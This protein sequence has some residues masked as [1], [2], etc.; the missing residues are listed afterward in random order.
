[1]CREMQRYGH[2][3]FRSLKLLQ[4][5]GMVLGLPEI[6]DSNDVCQGCVLGKHH[7][8]PFS[9]E[10]TWRT[11]EPLEL[12]HSDVCGPMKVPTTSAN[13]YFLMF[14]DDYSR[15]C[16]VYFIRNKSEVFGIFKKFR[17]MVELQCGYSLK[18]LRSDRGGEFTSTEFNA[19][20]ES[21]GME[22]QLTVIY[23]IAVE[24]LGYHVIGQRSVSTNRW[25]C[26]K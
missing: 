12:I 25:N 7:R 13:R 1:M 19:F 17:A 8:E 5:E 24:P 3:N 22:R 16:W 20:C 26:S 10:I 18:K 6:Q 2:L 4:S 15:I 14:I 23:H 9:K 11:Q 21:I